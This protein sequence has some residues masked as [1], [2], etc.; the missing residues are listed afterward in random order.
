MKHL[1]LL[2]PGF[3]ADTNDESCIPALQWLVKGFLK[4]GVTVQVIALEYPFRDT[5]YDWHGACIYPCNGQN[6]RL[7]KIRTL[8]RADRWCR[9][10]LKQTPHA[11][12]LSAWLGW[13]SLLAERR[14]KK[15]GR[16]HFTILMGQD[17][18]PA[19]RLHLYGLN[20]ERCRRLIAVSRQQNEIFFQNTGFY[21]AQV[22]PWGLEAV[23]APGDAAE[24]RPLDVLGVGSL[25]EVKNWHKW[26]EVLA[27]ATREKQDLRAELVGDGPL[28]H[29]LRLRAEQWGIAGQAG[30]AGALPRRSVLQKMQSAKVL[31]HT[32]DFESYGLV[33]AEAAQQGCHLVSTP[34]GIAPEIGALMADSPHKLAEILLETLQKA[35]PAAPNTPFAGAQTLAQYHSLLFGNSLP[36]PDG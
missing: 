18:L 7:F 10:L 5:P 16:P 22:I 34:V 31:L 29:E 6:K 2:T 4:A 32:A 28:M 19:N 15:S 33:L 11:S 12:L 24:N 3:A 14:A 26:L 17:V 27:V 21:A 23:D 25:V 9:R 36:L 30:F 20:A 8:Y 13:T 35:A 1:L